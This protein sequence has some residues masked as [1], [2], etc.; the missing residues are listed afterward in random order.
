MAFVVR[1]ENLDRV[2]RRWSEVLGLQFDEVDD[3]E[4]GLRVMVD[5]TAGLEL[6]APHGPTGR[7]GPFY[8]RYL[9]EHGEGFQTVVFRV[10]DLEA[11]EQRAAAAGIQILP[12]VHLTGDESFA[13]RFE[14]YVELPLS[15]IC[16]T[17][18]VVADIE[19]R[20]HA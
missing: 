18:V 14:R 3:E 15:P 8:T 9:E 12:R 13:D 1:P 4:I 16:G 10:D 5:M 20:D 19:E 6:I 17:H 11:A 7:Y 2:A